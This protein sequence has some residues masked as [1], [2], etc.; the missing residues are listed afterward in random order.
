M[1]SHDSTLAPVIGSV[2]LSN[3]QVR[4]QQTENRPPQILL[5]NDD[6][7]TC[8]LVRFL[9]EDAGYIVRI[10]E[11]RRALITAFS[12]VAPDLIIL[13][14]TLGEASG[15]DICSKIRRS[16]KVPMMFLSA[17]A[18]TE[19]RVFGL[20]CGAD[21][22]ITRPFE[23]AELLARIEALLRRCRRDLHPQMSQLRQ[24]AMTLYP[25]EQLIVFGEDDAIVLTWLETR[26]LHY[27]MR[28]AGET[29]K[30]EHI[31][32]AIWQDDQSDARVRLQVCISRLRLKLEQ[33]SRKGCITTIH[34]VGYRFEHHD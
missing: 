16:S 27:L 9:L 17:Y 7:T 21:D 28:H 18:T 30:S 23:P 24:G 8:K 34:N 12:T 32:Q 15:F 11:N 2:E 22:Y 33:Y 29:L 19:E 20:H 13:D 10:A 14:M 25:T 5:A 26:V 31:C 1:P 3:E 4:P 6:S